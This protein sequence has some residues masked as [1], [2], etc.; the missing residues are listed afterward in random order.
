MG[1]I[2]FL[3]ANGVDTT[4]SIE[5]FGEDTYKEVLEVFLREVVEKVSKLNESLL[6]KN[7]QDYATYVH[8]IKG[9]SSYLG[10]TELVRQATE[11]QKK[12]QAGDVNY[13]TTNYLNLVNEVNRIINVAKTY[14]GKN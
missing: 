6:N 11:H 7:L 1:D 2:N 12:A 10:F 5:V 14:L 9:E 13:I 8:A 3:R 4:S